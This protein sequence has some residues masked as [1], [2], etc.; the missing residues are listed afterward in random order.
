MYMW[1]MV[2][3]YDIKKINMKGVPGVLEISSLLNTVSLVVADTVLL[4]VILYTPLCVE[5]A[6]FITNILLSLLLL[7]MSVTV[8]ESLNVHVMSFDV[9]KGIPE[10]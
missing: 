6:E 5:L 10:A 4:I 7:I 9:M 2:N 8:T 3:V 1:C